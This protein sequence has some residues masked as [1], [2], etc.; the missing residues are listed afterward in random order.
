MGFHLSVL[1]RY[2]VRVAGLA[3]VGRGI[4]RGICTRVNGWYALA[5]VSP[6]YSGCIE[7][8]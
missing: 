4:G 1:G 7:G 5:H 6:E 2:S 8:L 3:G